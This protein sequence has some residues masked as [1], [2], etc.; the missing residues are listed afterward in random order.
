MKPE[1]KYESVYRRHYVM[2]LQEKRNYDEV[3][4]R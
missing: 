1:E 3:T 2:D 4:G